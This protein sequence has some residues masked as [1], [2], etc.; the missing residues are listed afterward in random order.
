LGRNC[1]QPQEA[2]MWPTLF[3]IILVMS[4]GFG[5]G[6]LLANAYERNVPW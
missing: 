6:S 2:R 3:A 1:R 5:L 4:L